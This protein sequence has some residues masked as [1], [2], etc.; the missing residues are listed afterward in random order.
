MFG[1]DPMPDKK[2]VAVERERGKKVFHELDAELQK[3]RDDGL[4]DLKTKVFVSRET[5]VQ[6]VS[7]IM[8]GVVRR[9]RAGEA[10]PLDIV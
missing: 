8:T 4:V 2:S 10:K 1:D 7:S 5:T 9:Y 6:R 3:L